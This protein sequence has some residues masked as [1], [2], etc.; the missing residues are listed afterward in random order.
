MRSLVRQGAGH[1]AGTSEQQ[2]QSDQHLAWA[3]CPGSQIGEGAAE[4]NRIASKAPNALTF[5]PSH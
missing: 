1:A 2:I 3:R 4:N 5:S